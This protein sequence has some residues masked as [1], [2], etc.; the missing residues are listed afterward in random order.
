MRLGEFDI[1]AESDGFKRTTVEGVDAEVGGPASVVIEMELGAVTEEITVSADIA[2][3]LVNTMDA[4]MGTV[5][6]DR[7][8]LELPLNG[9]N[10]VE[11]ALQQAGV[12]FEKSPDGQGDKLF[13]NGQRHQAIQMTLDGVDIQDNLNKSSATMID[14]PLLEIAAENVQ[15]FRVVTGLASA[16]YAGGSAHVSAITRSGSNDFD[17]SVFWFNRNDAFSANDFI[18][19]NSTPAVETP[20]L[21][22][23]QFGARIGGPIIEDKLFF[24]LGY[25]QTRESRGNSVNRTVYT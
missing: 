3:M 15:E 14:Q 5:V 21:N 9:R 24:Y 18:D 20:P 8:V 13:I 11:L 1:T 23:N 12:F 7:R 16:E 17:G 4:E 25:Q 19:N 2:Q 22:R 10:A 6:D